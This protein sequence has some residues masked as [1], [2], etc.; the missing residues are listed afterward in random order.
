MGPMDASIEMVGHERCPRED[1]S[2]MLNR[3]VLV[4]Q[5]ASY[6]S[7][8]RMGRD[9][10]NHRGQPITQRNR[11]V[12]QEDEEVSPRRPSALVTGLGEAEIFA[13]P[14]DLNVAAQLR[15]E[16]PGIVGRMIVYDDDFVGD[17]GR[18]PGQFC[19]TLL[20][21]LPLIP[22]RNDDGT[23]ERYRRRGRWVCS[24]MTISPP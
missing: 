4:E 22:H 5:F 17:A 16:M 13:V 10:C 20:G 23:V 9:L 14:D 3:I 11:I 2:C 19:Q 15:E 18:D 12:V 1:D 6:N 7:D 8:F 21:Q 24:G